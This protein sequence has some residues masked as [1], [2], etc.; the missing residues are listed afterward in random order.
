ME[1]ASVVGTVALSST[2]PAEHIVVDS[3]CSATQLATGEPTLS[4][5][6]GIGVDGEAIPTIL[7]RARD[8]GRVTGLVTD[9]RLTHATPAAFAAHVAHRSMENEIAADLLG[10]R[11]DLLLGGGARHFAGRSSVAAASDPAQL[12]AGAFAVT[13]RRGDDRDLLEEAQ[14]AGYALVFDHRAL[15]AVPRLPVLG[16]FADSAMEDGITAARR[17]ADPTRTEPTLREMTEAALRLLESHPEGFFLMVEGGQ[18]DWAGHDNDPGMLLREMLR[19][20]DAIDVVLAWAEGRD[21]TLVVI[22]ADHETGG[23][24]FTY[25]GYDVPTPE[26]R[27]GR[28][29]LERPYHPNFNFVSFDVFDLLMGQTVTMRQLFEVFDA[30]EDRTPEVL[31]EVVQDLT[32]YRLTEEQAAR[33]L[34]RAPNPLRVEGHAY[35]ANEEGPH[36][37][38]ASPFYPYGEA[39]IIALLS[40][41]LATQLHITWSTGTHTHTPVPVIVVGPEAHRRPFDRL[42]HHVEVGVLMQ[43]AMGLRP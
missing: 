28:A 22:T 34:E 1:R 32:D 18:I 16:L 7:E 38:E 10:E 3:A 11:V 4:E 27:S 8:S 31:V 17:A 39:S 29:F 26:P 33:V 9:T 21:D 40:R 37:A 24:S 42:L 35:L 43:R 15:A 41:A 13:S 19:F 2:G 25:S 30:R 5:V 6:I 14:A 12:S 23:F 20:D 36:M